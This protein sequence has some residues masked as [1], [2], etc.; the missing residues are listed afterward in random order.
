MA[1]SGVSGREG[2]GGMEGGNGG[3]LTI[4]LS[5]AAVVARPPF[6][7]LFPG[8]A[9]SPDKKKFARLLKACADGKMDA[10]GRTDI[11]PWRGAAWHYC[12]RERELDGNVVVCCREK[13]KGCAPPV[14]VLLSLPTYVGCPD[15]NLR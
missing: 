2:R 8:I 12:A 9:L 10:D 15:F 7:P 14:V 5:N 3:E 4:P 6:S 13:G 1:H 11:S